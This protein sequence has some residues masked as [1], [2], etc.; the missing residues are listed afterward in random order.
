MTWVVQELCGM[1]HDCVGGVLGRSRAVPF[2]ADMKEACWIR[3]R[4]LVDR[5]KI[6]GAFGDIPPFVLSEGD[7]DY[8][9]EAWRDYCYVAD[10]M[11]Q[12]LFTI[13]EH[14]RYFR[15][16]LRHALAFLA[17]HK[18]EAL[19]YSS[20]PHTISAVLFYHAARRLGLQNII[21]NEE[22]YGVIL[23][24]EW[25]ARTKVT[26]DPSF[27][28]DKAS[29]DQ[30]RYL[31]MLLPMLTKS[32]ND[33]SEVSFGDMVKYDRHGKMQ[34]Q[35]LVNQ[36]TMLPN[37]SYLEFRQPFWM[38]ASRDAAYLF[39]EIYYHLTLPEKFFYIGSTRN[40]LGISNW[41]RW[42][43]FK[44][45]FRNKRHAKSIYEHYVKLSKAMTPN[46]PYIYLA[47][48]YQ[49]ELTTMPKG[50][51]FQDQFLAAAMLAKALPPGWKLYIKENPRQFWG[52][53]PALDLAAHKFR[54]KEMYD[55]LAKLPNTQL[56]PI[57]S[58]NYSMIRNAEIC[59]TIGGT[60]RLEAMLMGKPAVT[61]GHNE[62]DINYGTVRIESAEDAAEAIK[63]LTQC[64]PEQIKKAG[65]QLLLGIHDAS[66]AVSFQGVRTLVG[67]IDYQ[68][69]EDEGMARALA[70]AID[71]RSCGGA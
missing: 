26:F 13:S 68:Q 50:G 64:D 70:L 33:A 38:R 11:S 28:M 62:V 71:K 54:T 5:L 47:L 42:N 56:V 32:S 69:G 55:E 36:Y 40:T 12:S 22:W 21:L 63:T 9:A 35:A 59:A 49:P 19:L 52:R 67:T 39:W 65:V 25:G 34:G 6:G 61:F 53:Y 15:D 24:E 41:P 14:K 30:K 27:S 4:T 44:A 37:I 51:H 66:T 17:H 45:T 18:I 10:R 23:K 57:E 29:R 16:F 1:G 3:Y 2:Y 60:T 31:E 43:S 46:V 58:S 20:I 7:L 8:F 48:H